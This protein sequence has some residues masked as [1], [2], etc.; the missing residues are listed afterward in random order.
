M[1]MQI[2]PYD[3]N[4]LE[5]CTTLWWRLYGDR[6]YVIRPDGYQMMNTAR[7]GPEFFGECFSKSLNWFGQVDTESIFVAKNQGRVVGM[8]VS[9]VNH[10]EHAGNILVSF[11]NRDNTG[12]EVTEELMQK[13]LS[14]FHKLGLHRANVGMGA[15]EVES[16]IYLAALEAGFSWQDNWEQAEDKSWNPLVRAYPGFLLQLGGSLDGFEL[17]AEISQT[18]ARLNKQGV[19]FKVM[20]V[21]EIGEHRRADTKKPP[22]DLNPQGSIPS[23]VALV[24]GELVG[25]FEHIGVTQEHSGMAARACGLQVIPNYRKRGIGKAM[26]HLGVQAMVEHGAEYGYEQAGVYSPARLILRSV[27][28]RY[29]YTSFWEMTKSLTYASLVW[30]TRAFPKQ[31]MH[32]LGG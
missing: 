18:I 21:D 6:P 3:D 4:L 9:S 17:S 14:Y 25:W 11:T 32:T 16:P 19:D 13:A 29:W 30:K 24:N 1:S 10:D 20:S 15:L 31:V 26:Y 8:L 2:V 12:R 22:D 23:S 7:I 27:G 5:Q 28:Y